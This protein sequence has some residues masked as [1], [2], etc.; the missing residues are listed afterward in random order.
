MAIG[1][2]MLGR[3]HVQP[4]VVASLAEIMVEGTFP[5]GTYLV[6]VHHPVATENGDI[7]KALYGSFLPIPSNDLFPSHEASVY[8]HEKQPGAIVAVKGPAGTI[9]LNPGRKRI[10]L[11]VKSMGDR[12]IQVGSH[13]HFIETN[14][15]LQFDRVRAHGYR[16]DI[17]AGTSVRF[18]PGDTKTVTLVQIAGNQIIKGGNQIATGY[19]E[20]PSIAA[21]I[22]QKLTAGGFLHEP[23]PAGD[24]AHIDICTMERQTYISMFGPTTGD[25]V[26]LGATDLWIKVEKDMTRYGDECAFGG[27]KTLREGMGQAGGRS[28][29]DVLDT[30]IT[31]ALIVDWTGIFKADIGIKDGMIVG[32]GKAGNPDV[33]DGVDPNLVVGSC[34][35]V[36]AGEHNIV[37]AG[38]FDTHIHFICPQQAQEAIASG[39]TTM[40]G[41]GTG[42]RSV[43]TPPSTSNTLTRTAPVPTQQHAHRAKHTSARC[44]RPLTPSRSTTASQAKATTRTCFP[45]ASKPKPAC[46]A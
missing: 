4:S 23:E 9:E 22:V 28:D 46:A 16:L 6:T 37:T 13:Y 30:V 8:E 41:G 27:G 24:A 2:T 14:P 39:I 17:P 31:N 12:P 35:D 21:D 34:T 19:I 10:K 11:R 15:Q 36:I 42:P 7:E 29:D 20:D 43:A 32:I 44:C 38:G 45:S 25:L 26:R 33:M 1:K 18:E 40:L 5:T 3:R